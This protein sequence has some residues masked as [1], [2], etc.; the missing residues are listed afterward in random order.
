M[1]SISSDFSQLSIDLHASSQPTITP[2]L[3]RISLQRDVFID[4]DHK[5]LDAKIVKR[6]WP[7]RKHNEEPDLPLLLSTITGDDKRLGTLTADEAEALLEREPS[8]SKVL[9]NSWQAGSFKEVRR[10]GAFLFIV[11]RANS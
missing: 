11:S 4:D 7:S 1:D 2:E 3:K 5:P 8:I 10:L 9:R 6:F